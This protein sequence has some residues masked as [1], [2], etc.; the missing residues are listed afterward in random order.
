MGGIFIFLSMHL[1]I[2]DALALAIDE[3]L[4]LICL[5]VIAPHIYLLTRKPVPVREEMENRLLRP[6]TLI[7]I[8]TVLRKTSQVDDAKI[9]A[10]C[11]IGIRSRFADIVETSP[12]KL[13]AHEIIVLHHIPGLFVRTAPGGMH[14]VVCRTLEGWIGIW[15]PPL[16]RSRI[17]AVARHPVITARLESRNT[18]GEDERLAREVPRNI[19]RPLMMII[20]SDDIDGTA[21]EEM[22]LRIRL[23]ASGCYRTGA[24]RIILLHDISQMTG[25]KRIHA[26][27]I[28]MCQGRGIMP[29][30]Q[31]EIRLLQTQGIGSGIR[32]LFEHLVADTPHD[33]A[34]MI[35]VALHQI[36]EITLVPFIEEA[37]II[38]IR[39]LAAPHVKALVH[40]HDSH[41]ITHIQ[42]FGSRR[43]MT[44]SD[45]IHTHIPEDGELAM[46][47]I[48]VEGGTETSE[49]VM[50]AHA[51]DLH[52]LAI[53]KETLPGIKPH[54]TE[55]G[56][57]SGGIHHLA[58]HH[59]F[60]LHGIEIALAD[61]PEMRFPYLE[62]L[63]LGALA[64]C[65]HLASRIVDGIA[66]G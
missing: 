29:R 19:L 12:D 61:R 4:Y 14:I 31:D 51:I 43:I 41:G 55:G 65:H 38:A 47:R 15:Q 45:G 2:P 28:A 46:K 6:F 11:R 7:H 10:A 62:L 20:E 50:L 27:L 64:P 13:T 17:D 48:L 40:H 30:I 32:P 37:G 21:L 24:P 34:R 22:I 52:I 3:Q 54:I 25:E 16:H 35:P 9:T 66:D 44:A 58:I 56:L 36:R 1:L 60:A 26:Q 39:L 57:R 59:Q 33:D 23:V 5:V 8:I 53:E 42:E 49:I 63:A 18:L